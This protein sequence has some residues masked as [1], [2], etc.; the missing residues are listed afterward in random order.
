[1]YYNSKLIEDM[2]V[3][4]IH[5]DAVLF[6]KKNNK[7]RGANSAILDVKFT[8]SS[9]EEQWKM[10]AFAKLRHNALERSFSSDH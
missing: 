3:N 10:I 9:M 2:R 8:S 1:M 5:S 6:L 4:Y 7:F